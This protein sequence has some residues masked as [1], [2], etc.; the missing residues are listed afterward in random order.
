MMTFA[1]VG[2]CKVRLILLIVTQRT[3]PTFALLLYEM[4]NFYSDITQHAFLEE[5]LTLLNTSQE[6]N[7]DAATWS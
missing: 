1:C 4:S 7:A 5:E 6:E 3:E 2:E